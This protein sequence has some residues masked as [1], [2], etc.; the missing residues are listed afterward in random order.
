MSFNSRFS[1]QFGFQCSARNGFV[2]WV[3]NRKFH[4]LS[5]GS[6][7]D[8]LGWHSTAISSNFSRNFT[9]LRIFGWTDVCCCLVDSVTVKNASDEWFSELCPIYQGC[10]ALIFASA[11]LSCGHWRRQLLGTVQAG[12]ELTGAGLGRSWA[13]LLN[14]RAFNIFRLFSQQKCIKLCEF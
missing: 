14:P 2:W 12:C 6:K 4:A 3:T 7:V 9:L 8:Y 11:R 10:R 13:A 5:I 1:I